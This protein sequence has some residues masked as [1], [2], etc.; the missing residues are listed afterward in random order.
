MVAKRKAPVRQHAIG[1]GSAPAISPRPVERVTKM[2]AAA[3]QK[4]VESPARR[5][6]QRLAAELALADNAREQSMEAPDAARW[7]GFA[8]L[9]FIG[10]ASVALWSMIIMIVIQ[11]K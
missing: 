6:Q 3:G 11:I 7:H 8:R 1:A 4:N 10:G 5:M 9:G 2:S